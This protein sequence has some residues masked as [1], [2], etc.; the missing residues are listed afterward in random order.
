MSLPKTTPNRSGSSCPAAS[1]ASA[2]ARPEAANPIW[3]S[4]LITLRLFRGR[5]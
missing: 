3:I 5:T 4:R 2:I 1:P